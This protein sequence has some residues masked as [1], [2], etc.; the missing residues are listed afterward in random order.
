[1]F[2]FFRIVIVVLVIHMIGAWIF[3]KTILINAE[4]LKSDTRRYVCVRDAVYLEFLWERLLI[5]SAL[6]I[7][8]KETSLGRKVYSCSLKYSS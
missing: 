7:P 3:D 6:S 2:S 5:E 1:M 8:F 4:N